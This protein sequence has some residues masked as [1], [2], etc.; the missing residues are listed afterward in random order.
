MVTRDFLCHSQEMKNQD[1]RNS[2]PSTRAALRASTSTSA[3]CLNGS[4]DFWKAPSMRRQ[5]FLPPALDSIV[6]D[7][8]R[9]FDA[10]LYYP[11]LLVALTLPEVC[12]ALTMEA[13]EFV[14]E[15]HYVSFVNEYTS[16]AGLGIDGLGC[17]RLRG[18]VVHRGNAAGHPFFGSSHVIFCVPETGSSF[19]AMSLQSGEKTSAVF[20]L[21][22][23]CTAMHNAVAK[24]Y[25]AHSLQPKV[26]SNLK[27]LLSW[28]PEGMAPFFEGA[29]I[30]GSGS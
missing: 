15:K 20:N 4:A 7:M 5:L 10:S 24:W 13:K 18:G 25:A 29:P 30:L 21:K 26:Q 19:H 2:K 8:W 3:I 23:F 22:Y 16:P 17:Y 27:N 14:K 1:E 28:R 11:A 6:S 9:A 12:V